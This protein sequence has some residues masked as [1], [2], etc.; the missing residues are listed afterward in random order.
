MIKGSGKLRKIHDLVELGKDAGMPE[1][2]LDEAKELTMAYIYSRYP[3]A[4]GK[5]DM[6][7][8]ASEFIGYARRI[9][10]W[11]EKNL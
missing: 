7:K 8:K 5:E 3:D 2:L 4:Q 1:E 10:E 9:V 6:E 11:S